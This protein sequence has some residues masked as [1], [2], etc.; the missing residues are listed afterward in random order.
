[1]IPCH[2][3]IEMFCIASLTCA[4]TDSF[5]RNRCAGFSSDDKIR[6]PILFATLWRLTDCYFQIALVILQ[7]LVHCS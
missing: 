7:P 2:H 4:D 5:I 3:V 6:K 1:M